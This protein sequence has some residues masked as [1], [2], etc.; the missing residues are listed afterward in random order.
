MYVKSIPRKSPKILSMTSATT[1]SLPGATLADRLDAQAHALLARAS[2]GLSPASALLA[3]QDWA[4]HLANSPGKQ[5]ALAQL[6]G[7]QAQALSQYMRARLQAAP[8]H[9]QV[10]V[11]P[12]AQDRRFVDPAWRKWPFC[13]WQQ[14]FLLTEQWWDAATHGVSGVDRHHENM[15]SFWARQWL[16]MFSPGNRL[17]TNPLALRRTVE[18]L[19]ANLVRGAQHLV[20]DL[21]QAVTGTGPET[22]FTVGRDVAVTPGQVV[23]R[24]RVME[25]IQYAPAT[26]LVHAEPVLLIPAWIMKYYILD[27][28][29]HDS[30]VKYLVDQGHTVFCISWKNPGEAERD[31]GMDDYRRDGFHAA[32]DAV[33]AI[34]PK[35]KVH[36][37]GYCLGGTL[38]AIAAAA[39]A[40]DGDTRLASTS[41]FAAQTDFSEP[42][43]LGL[44]IDASQVSL[45]EAQ[46]AK[47]GYLKASQMAG[48]FQ[49][50][51]SYDLLWSRLV[52]DYLLGDR[53]GFNDLMA[54]NADTTR[55][56][57]TMH[58]QYLRRL[59]LN[60]DLSEGRYPVDGRPVS[61][62]SLTLP[63]FMVGTATDHVAP[64]RS[65]HKLHYLCPAEITFVL[66][67]GGHNAGIVNPP[68]STSKRQ[69]QWLTREAGG[70]YLAPDEWLAA[71]S[72]VRGSWWPAWQQWLAARSGAQVKPPRMGS[73]AYPA[74]ADAP[75]S[76]V[77]EK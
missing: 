10:L 74:T 6:A 69:Y 42:G 34:L 4:V 18:E 40:R 31:L 57:A 9:E 36:A 60:D 27:L 14:S 70:T 49:M 73:S 1:S 63:T 50:L 66:T 62:G 32:L 77:L 28:S 43:E 68:V 16:D 35:R 29:P 7:T 65:V 13:L 3:W 48:A 61:L 44:F 71:A 41:Y 51:R 46:M 38:L 20:E 12:P 17:A 5:M 56:P 2:G 72:T 47:T 37:A 64:W 25:L 67:S 22:G 15:V 55:M 21:Q 26:G 33:N 11:E 52:H 23:L 59:F 58:S 53:S 75:G 8:D 24:N 39:M 30:L 54:W 19:G 45:L 76:Y